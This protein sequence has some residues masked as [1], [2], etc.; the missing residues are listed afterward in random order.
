MMT[1][2]QE[3]VVKNG[4]V[5]TMNK[6]R[7]V[8]EGSVLIENGKIVEV[9]KG[10]E[11][12][13]ADV[14][15]DAGGGIITPGFICAHTHLYGILLRGAYL[16]ITPPTDFTQNLQRI[17][18]L[19]DEEMNYNDAYISS[20]MAS[21]E[22]LRAGTTTFADTF[23]GPNAIDGVLDHIERGVN[24]VG[25]RGI[26][27][28]ESTQRRSDDEGYRGLRENERFI[29]RS[30]R[31]MISVHASFTVRDE[32]LKEAER[33]ASELNVPLTIHASEGKW[34][35]YHNLERY[36]KRTFERLNDL[37]ILNPRAVIAHAVNVNEDELNI[38]SRTHTNI[39]HNPL[40]NMLNAVGVAPVPEMKKLGINLSLGN[41]GYIFDTFENMR[42]AF[43]M[44]KLNKLDPRVMSF[45]DVLEMSTINAARAYGLDKSLGSLEAGK[46]ADVVV[47][48]PAIRPTPLTS[49][50]SYA[51]LINGVNAKDVDT[52]IVNGEV[53]LSGGN[54]TKIDLQSANR[55][56]SEMVQDY[57]QRLSKGK[58]RIE[59]L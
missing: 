50:S 51:Y 28:F 5:V 38:I 24:E 40:S 31:G 15:I 34:D 30:G 6:D 13:K 10:S 33:M 2:N 19:M 55:K 44:H 52:A 37:G 1:M 42:A 11:S 45:L 23:S 25:I 9:N 57:W 17:W 16:N 35:L 4:I 56:A 22:L 46:L 49:S 58:E 3:T 36:G 41:D 47:L 21:L 29:K 26:L 32:L 18:W 54:P 53:V 7:E 39:V 59:I 27:S 14:E 8:F 12:P 43:L 20:L 48:K